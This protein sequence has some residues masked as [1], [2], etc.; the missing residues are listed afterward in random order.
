[1]EKRL[2]IQQTEKWLFHLQQEHTLQLRLASEQGADNSVLIEGHDISVLLDY[3][4]DHRE[5]I[6]EATHDQ[7]RRDLEAKAAFDGSLAHELEKQPVEP[8]RYFDDGI[9]R[10]RAGI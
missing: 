1:M 2:P 7:E 10:T 4:Y 8:A 5:M 3:L 9:R 6:Y